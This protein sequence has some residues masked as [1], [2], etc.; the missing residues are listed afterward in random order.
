VLPT[1]PVDNQ[2]DF[3]RGVIDVDDD[4]LDQRPHE[5]LLG[6]HVRRRCLPRRLEIPGERQQ[7]LARDPRRAHRCPLGQPGL[8]LLQSRHRGVPPRLELGSHEPIVR[9]DGLVAPPGEDDI[10]LSLLALELQRTLTLIAM[11][12]GLSFGHEGSVHGHRLHRKKNLVRDGGIRTPGPRRDAAFEAVHRVTDSA[13]VSRLGSAAASA[14]VGDVEHPTTAP[15]PE[16]AGEQGV[17]P[18]AGLRPAGGFPEGIARQALLILFELFPC[19]VR[20]VVIA[21]ERRPCVHRSPPSVG[22]AHGPFADRRPRLRLAVSVGPRVERILQDGD[23]GAV[24]GRPPCDGESVPAVHRTRHGQALAPHVQQDLPGAAQA[25][26]EPED[27]ADRLLDAP[28]RIHHQPQLDRPD[29]ADRDRHSELTSARLGQGGLEQT[30]AQERELELAHRALEPEQQAVIRRAGIVSAVGVDDVRAHEAA[31]F[32]EMMP[33]P[34]IAGETRRLETKHGPDQPFADLPDEAPKARTLHRATGRTSK[35][36]VNHPDVLEAVGPGQ[37]PEGVL[38]TLTLE[39]LLHLPPGRLPNV[40][41][42][43]AAQHRRRQVTRHHRCP[44][45]CAL[46]ARLAAE[47]GQARR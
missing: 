17:A 39:I 45:A 2:H 34:P 21:H 24:D 41:D 30:L 47:A 36:V 32:E 42:G 8:T 13:G 3:A 15:T 19:D 11:L 7:G 16:K 27:D 14:A 23:H 38:P 1:A 29:I 25:V 40:D 37:I 43:A 44:P 18:T 33:V 28:V 5:P 46:V 26:E 35:V 9:V 6:A 4:L 10:V 22:F 20:L 12:T 31:E